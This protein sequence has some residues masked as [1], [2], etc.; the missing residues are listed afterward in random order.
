[1][2]LKSRFLLIIVTGGC[3]AQPDDFYD[4]RIH[5]ITSKWRF[6]CQQIWEI[7]LS[8]NWFTT[9]RRVYR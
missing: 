7:S 6:S 8:V 4:L 1:M 3:S 9:Y 2:N 5:T